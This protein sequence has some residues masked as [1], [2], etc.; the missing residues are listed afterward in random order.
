MRNA[1]SMSASNR[2]RP[3][4]QEVSRRVEIEAVRGR[5]MNRGQGGYVSCQPVFPGRQVRGCVRCCIR[6]CL[7]VSVISLSFL[8]GSSNCPPLVW[9]PPLGLGAESCG[10]SPP[11]RFGVAVREHPIAA[12][13]AIAT[14]GGWRAPR[15]LRLR[16]EIL[17][18]R[19]SNSHF[20][21]SARL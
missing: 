5:A 14:G 2:C 1:V 18:R 19:G 6:R 3:A 20:L 15:L 11:D 16:E 17:P 21:G 9:A 13:L 7:P 4:I 8:E 10:R 12:V